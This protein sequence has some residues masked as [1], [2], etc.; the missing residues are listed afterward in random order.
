MADK[1]MKWR[2]GG[3]TYLREVPDGEV[4]REAAFY[5]MYRSS[6]DGL[7]GPEEV[8]EI[9]MFG[10]NCEGWGA[11]SPFRHVQK[12]P[13]IGPWRY[14]IFKA[15]FA[16][17][18]AAGVLSNQM[19]T[20]DR[21]DWFPDI[22]LWTP[23]SFVRQTVKDFLEAHDPEGHLFF[24]TK[25][26]GETSG[27]EIAGGP[28]YQWMPARRLF[29]SPDFEIPSGPKVAKKVLKG[30]FGSER[31]AWQIQYNLP[32][33]KFLSTLPCFGIN[34]DYQIGFNAA[35]FR[36]LKEAGFTGLVEREHDDWDEPDNI[37]WNIGHFE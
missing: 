5:A 29:M 32:F 3:K 6:I 35:M 31:I 7:I 2:V 36:A 33:R 21:A 15:D 14:E 18:Q 25:I 24:S 17:V 22:F 30:R 8:E 20:D 1:K 34:F 28:Y 16:A 19:I 11:D 37:N 26:F 13:D 9:K 23:F 27:K 4:K 12:T 10:A